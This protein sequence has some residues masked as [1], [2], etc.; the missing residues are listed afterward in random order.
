MRPRTPGRELHSIEALK[1]Q[2]ALWQQWCSAARLRIVYLNACSAL[3]LPWLLLVNS[4]H[5]L[6]GKML[7]YCYHLV[8]LPMLL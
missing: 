5:V 2:R 6:A 3:L 1:F 7:I 8:L 4:M